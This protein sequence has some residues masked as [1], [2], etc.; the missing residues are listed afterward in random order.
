M[1][2]KDV[3]IAENVVEEITGQAMN[4]VEG[5]DKDDVEE[6]VLNDSDVEE[7]DKNDVK[8]VEK[9]N[10]EVIERND[11]EES[12][13]ND[14]DVEEADK[15]DIEE[16]VKNDVVVESTLKGTAQNDMKDIAKEMERAVI[17]FKTNMLYD[18]ALA[19]NIEV[20]LP[21]AQDRFSV[22]AEWWFPWLCARNNSWCYQLL[23][24]GVEGRIWL[25]N[26]NERPSLSGHFL[27]IYGGGGLFDLGYDN[28]GYQNQ[29]YWSAGITYGYSFPIHRNL[30][31]ETSVSVGYISAEY[32]CYDVVEDGRYMVWRHDGKFSWIGPTKAKV[33]L[34]WT[35]F[36]KNKAKGD[37]R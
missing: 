35:I 32:A 36:N 1:I 24:G 23:Y 29:G 11:I 18:L 15:N 7:A 30:R 14:N 10:V 3:V 13:L 26:R 27:G 19:P 31:I 37:L 5:I 6:G 21:F 28:K 34:V 4:D 20:E 16:V 9:N 22:M 12:V 2:Q 17:A 33:S 25:G 8:E